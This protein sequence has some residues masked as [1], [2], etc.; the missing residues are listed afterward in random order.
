MN[1]QHSTLRSRARRLRRNQT[2]AERKLWFELRNRRFSSVKFRRQHP[3]GRFVVDFCCPKRDLV[4]GLDGGQH[5]TRT[6]ADQERTV[7]LEQNGY[8]VLR[9]WNHEVIGN[10]EAILQ[11]IEQALKNPHPN[12]LPGRSREG[13]PA[14]RRTD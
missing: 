3:I 14:L 12:P 4:I 10:I 9:F 8:Q 5:A 1:T 7:F 11:Q 2:D 13:R 6:E